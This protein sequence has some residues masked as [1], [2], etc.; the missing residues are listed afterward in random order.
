[1]GK[2]VGASVRVRL[3]NQAQAEKQDFDFV[4]GRWPVHDGQ[5]Q[6]RDP[7]ARLRP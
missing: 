4:V 1:M 2:A 3:Y 5:G 7:D 6:G